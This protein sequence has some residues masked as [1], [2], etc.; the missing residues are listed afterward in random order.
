MTDKTTLG[1]R[2]KLYEASFKTVLPNRMRARDMTCPQK[3]V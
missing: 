1:D 3:L 2:M